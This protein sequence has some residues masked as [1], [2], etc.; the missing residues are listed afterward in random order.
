MYNLEF[1]KVKIL[2]YQISGT[3][4][5]MC[6][7]KNYKRIWEQNATHAYNFKFNN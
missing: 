6:A 1:R 5:L 2:T 3:Y 7:I 4:T